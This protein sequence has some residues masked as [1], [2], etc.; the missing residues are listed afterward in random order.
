M[1]YS[2]RRPTVQSEPIEI[3]KEI[4]IS[5]LPELSREAVTLQIS[6][7]YEHN[8]LFLH[9]H[10]THK[11]TCC[12]TRASMPI[13]VSEMYAKGKKPT[14]SVPPTVEQLTPIAATLANAAKN[15]EIIKVDTSRVVT[16]FWV[17]RFYFM[18]TCHI[19][20]LL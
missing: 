7:L 5:N 11:E 16:K 18:S 4:C 14:L 6:V 12:E 1:A 15:V 17:T 3:T 20:N 8:Q 19:N 2:N 13:K 10:I 9:M